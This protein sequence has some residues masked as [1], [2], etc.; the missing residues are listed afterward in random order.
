MIIFND[1]LKKINIISGKNQN[2]Y[3]E[4][5]CL[6]ML[7]YSV[8]KYKVGIKAVIEETFV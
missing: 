1:G 5:T 8:E 6:E 4:K 2:K 7:D 3:I